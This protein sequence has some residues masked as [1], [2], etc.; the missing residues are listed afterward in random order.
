MLGKLARGSLSIML[1]LTSVAGCGLIPKSV[2]LPSMP[3]EWDGEIVFIP[4]Y[5]R[6]G[7]EH[8]AAALS[9]QSGPTHPS[10]YN[11]TAGRPDVAIL[12]ER[13]HDLDRLIELETVTSGQKARIRGTMISTS[14]VF[15]REATIGFSRKH[16]PL[17][18]D[19]PSEF[20]I[21]VSGP[22]RILKN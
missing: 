10:V 12:V 16:V 4:V 2:D 17:P 9:I 3:G 19:M 1:A 22:I 20:V 21:V 15:L 11:W 5:E 18:A 13:Y 7:K 8:L 14:S 6:K